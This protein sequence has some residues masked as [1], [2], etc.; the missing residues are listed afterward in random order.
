MVR[1]LWFMGCI[2]SFLALGQEQRVTTEIVAAQLFK[3]GKAVVTERFV[4]DG[5]GQFVVQDLPKFAHGTFWVDKGE[6]QAIRRVQRPVER[7]LSVANLQDQD[8]VM[9]GKAVTVFLTNGERHTG[10]IISKPNN[11]NSEPFWLIE[12]KDQFLYLQNT[13]IKGIQVQKDQ[14]GSNLVVKQNAPVLIFDIPKKNKQVIQFSYLT[15]GL[16]WAPSYRLDLLDEQK[17][18]IWQKAL[19][20]NEY[21]DLKQTQ[22]QLISG[23][24]Q[25]EFGHVTSPLDPNL[26]WGLFMTMLNQNGRFPSNRTNPFSNSSTQVRSLSWQPE[27]GDMGEG[28]QPSKDMHFQDLGLLT[29]AKDQVLVK[30]IA[31]QEIAYRREIVCKTT[32][33]RKKDG[34][35]REKGNVAEVVHE[36]W[37]ELV[38]K[39][40]F[41]F[42]MTT[43][44]AIVFEANRIIGQAKSPWVNPGSETRLRITKALSLTVKEEER[45]VSKNRTQKTLFNQIYEEETVEVRFHIHNTRNKTV[46][47]RLSKTFFGTLESAGDSPKTET[48]K[49]DEFSVNRLNESVWQLG[50]EAGERKQ[51][52]LTYKILV[53]R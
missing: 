37:E 9:K 51:I 2:G 16:G 48:L 27:P 19:V 5:S 4:T 17:L 14:A 43:A 26:N 45:V 11:F 23:Y 41:S 29:L 18:R 7:T 50:L 34:Y 22:I 20:R 1:I 31:Q 44:P 39:N 52:N 49:E 33:R 30:E 8:L 53:R 6:V 25:L 32:N 21:R 12:T 3:N 36:A 38:F 13:E 46:D 40:P 47:L 10:R 15:N 28:V 42:P 35:L 24:P